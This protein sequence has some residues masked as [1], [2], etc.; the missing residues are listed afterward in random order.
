MR[1]GIVGET[2]NMVTMHVILD[3]QWSYDNSKDEAYLR[4]V[5]LPLEVRFSLPAS[6]AGFLI[7]VQAVLTVMPA[8]VVLKTSS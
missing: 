2:N 3:T 5:S 4:R 6:E 1:S 7:A 8:R